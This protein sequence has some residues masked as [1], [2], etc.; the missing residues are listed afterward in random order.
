ME[1]DLV[2]HC[3]ETA[4]GTY[5]HTLSATDI[6]TGWT[7]CIALPTKTQEETIKAIDMLRARLPFPLLGVDSDN[8]TE[9][10]NG[11]LYHYCRDNEITLTRCRPYQKK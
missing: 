11:L 10:I 6:V 7:E 8:G 5:L 9:F 3:G 4:V 2:A 1:V